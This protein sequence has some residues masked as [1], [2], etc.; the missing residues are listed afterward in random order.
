MELGQARFRFAEKVIKLTSYKKL[1]HLRI[2][3]N[4]PRPLGW[5]RTNA[6]DL[7]AQD[8]VRPLTPPGD[9]NEKSPS[10]QASGFFLRFFRA[11]QRRPK[12]LVTQRAFKRTIRIV[13]SNVNALKTNV[14]P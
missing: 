8:S 1:L 10:L 7:C 13:E 4:L 2:T 14:N 5:I 11:R 6:S 3:V 12:A 9:K